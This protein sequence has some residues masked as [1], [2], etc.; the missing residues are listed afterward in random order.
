VGGSEIRPYNHQVLLR[1]NEAFLSIPVHT[2]A[3]KSHSAVGRFRRRMHRWL[4]LHHVHQ[5][6]AIAHTVGITLILAGAIAI[7]VGM[8]LGFFDWTGVPAG[9]TSRTTGAFVANGPWPGCEDTAS[10]KV[11]G[12]KYTTRVRSITTNGGFSPAGSYCGNYPIGSAVSIAY[13]PTNPAHAS[14]QFNRPLLI[15][16]AFLL[17]GALFVFLGWLFIPPP[18]E[19]PLEPATHRGSQGPDSLV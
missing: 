10:F 7:I 17:L 12:R 5:H 13:S 16:I 8:A 14:V 15:W 1:R 3:P 11:D 4:R 6:R 9:E 19:G 18:Q 2:D